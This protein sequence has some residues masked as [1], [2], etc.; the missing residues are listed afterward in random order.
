MSLLNTSILLM[1]TQPTLSPH[2]PRPSTSTASLCLFIRLNAD[3][4]AGSYPFLILSSF[5]GFT[6]QY[7]FPS[8]VMYLILKT[9]GFLN[10]TKGHVLYTQQDKNISLF[11]LEAGARQIRSFFKIFLLHNT[12]FFLYVTVCHDHQKTFQNVKRKNTGAVIAD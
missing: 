10:F 2:S 9:K 12:L 11:I 4:W 7:L 6:S 3:K 5:V 1:C 8:L